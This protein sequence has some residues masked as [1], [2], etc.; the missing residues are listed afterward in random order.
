[1]AIFMG[2]LIL[3]STFFMAFLAILYDTFYGNSGHFVWHFLWQF[4][5]FL[6]HSLWKFWPFLGHFCG[7]LYSI[8]M[9]NFAILGQFL[10]QFFRDLNGKLRMLGAG[11]S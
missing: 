3:F 8:F 1:M 2:I 7:I 10:L 9:G 4:W 11:C 6:G 5:S